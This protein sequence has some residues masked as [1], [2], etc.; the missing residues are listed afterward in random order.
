MWAGVVLGWIFWT[1]G[2]VAGLRERSR[3]IL[4]P[5][6]RALS[7]LVRRPSDVVQVDRREPLDRAVHLVGERSR[8]VLEAAAIRLVIG[9]SD[10]LAASPALQCVDDAAGIS[11][12]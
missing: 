11:E 4:D 3:E 8:D 10:I 7:L 9:H 12:V 1:A 5:S 2:G 6:A